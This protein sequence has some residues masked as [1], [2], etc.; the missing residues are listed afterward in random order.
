MAHIKTSIVVRRPRAETFAYLTDLRNAK[1]WS[2]EVVDVRYDGDDLRV[3]TTGVDTRRMG[4]KQ[5]E[6]PWTVTAY[7]P[8]RRIVL[9]YGGR[10]AATAD[11]S[12]AVEP[13]GTSVTCDTE[14][15]PRGLWRLLT[16]LMAA[17]ARKADT[18]Q[19]KKI[20]Q[21]LESRAES[22][23]REARGA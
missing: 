18:V 10:F 17:E 3:G 8:P 7:E 12:F 23:T 6:M 9:E 11:F 20:K 21:I 15:R 14:L 19:F 13:E 16:P 2:T 5:L 4:S 1:E 22:T